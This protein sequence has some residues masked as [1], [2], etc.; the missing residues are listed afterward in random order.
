MKLTSVLITGLLGLLCSF[1][2]YSLTANFTADESAVV[3]Y[4][5]GFDSEEELDGWTLTRTNVQNSWHLAEK[6]YVNGVPAFTSIDPDSKYS[7][8]IRYD[9]YDLQNEKFTSPVMEILPDTEMAFYSCFS[10]IFLFSSQWKVAVIDEAT[11]ERTVVFDAFKWAQEVGYDGPSWMPFNVDLSAM[12][13]K[14][15]RI[16][17]EYEGMGGEDVLVDGL[18]LRQRSSGEVA[19]V[20]INVGE[21]V[22][23]RSLAEGATSWE[24]TFEGGNPASSTDEN[25]VVRYDAPGKYT[26]KLV[27]GNGTETAEVIRDAFVE[28]SEVA[29]KAVIGL[30]EEG[31]QSPWT[32]C[33]VPVGVPVQFRDLSTGSPTTWEWQLQGTD[34]EKTT[35]QNPVATYQKKGAYSLSLRVSNSAG[36]STDILQYAVQAGGAQYIWNI[37]PEE[38]AS[39]AP[40]DLAYYGYYGGTNWLGMEAFAEHFA[41]PLAPATVSEV[42]IYFASIEA[43]TT[44]A[45]I[46]VSLTE[47]DD[48]GMPGNVLASASLPVT[49]LQYADDTFKET[50]FKFATPVQV[51]NEFFVTVSGFPNKDNGVAVD[52]VSMFCSP[53]REAGGK[54]TTYHLLQEWD[55][56]DQ[57]TGK[58]EWFKGDEAISFALCPLLDY[59]DDATVADVVST[60]VR[61]FVAG[62]ML[63]IEAPKGY[64]KA[65]VYN[66]G[67]TAVLTATG[68]AEISLDSLPR[69]IYIVA[70][71]SNG[72]HITAKIVK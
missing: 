12:A 7:L 49:E 29:P 11:Q 25:P 67:G 47:V 39:L 60:D 21:E 33:F 10:G 34:K 71:E 64:Q 15:V 16:S 40:V 3:Y 53:K 45:V 20:K 27:V 55:D 5:Q 46:T 6:P 19:S 61:V 48:K 2:A 59:G 32:G 66:L 17:F 52:N 4:E 24:W 31:Y 43:V 63:R 22:H 65:T 38:N 72:K 8:A 62:G 37:A 35:E 30:P 54:C 13:G 1:N 28:V 9:D 51:T 50:V 68:E 56:N 42:A 70:V 36:V 18:E 14:Q 58:V 69:G 41:A 44:D 57:P 26:V 23:F